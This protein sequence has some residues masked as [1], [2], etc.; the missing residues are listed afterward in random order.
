[1][2]YAPSKVLENLP[3]L[4]KL[5]QQV[6]WDQKHYGLP[7]VLM[8][9]LNVPREDSDISRIALWTTAGCDYSKNRLVLEAIIQTAYFKDPGVSRHVYTWYPSPS[10]K[11]QKLGIGMRI[12][13]IL[14]DHSMT[15]ETFHVNLSVRGTDHRPAPDHHPTTTL[16]CCC[17]CNSS[18]SPASFKRIDEPMLR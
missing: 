1:M 7:L 9:D 16:E 10:W 3:F 5:H 17:F 6:I 2:V 15:I 11:S 18:R 12:D 8:G 4:E 14:H 13:Y